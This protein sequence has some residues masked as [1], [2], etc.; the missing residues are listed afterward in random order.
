M[1]L[2]DQPYLL[3]KMLQIAL[4]PRR[5]RH[6]QLSL[7]PIFIDQVEIVPFSLASG[8]MGLYVASYGDSG[9]SAVVVASVLIIMQILMV[10][11]RLLSRHLQSVTLGPDDHVLMVATAS[12]LWSI[13]KIRV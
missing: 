10:S 2:L 7:S 4:G 12:V 13:W 8:K 6:V 11:G 1:F 3:A 5:K 9:Y